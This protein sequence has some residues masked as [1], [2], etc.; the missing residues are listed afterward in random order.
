MSGGFRSLFGFFVF[1]CILRSGGFRLLSGY[2]PGGCRGRFKRLTTHEEYKECKF[3]LL[4]GYF[5]PLLRIQR[6]QGNTEY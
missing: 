2:L 5:G 6:M 1:Y 3:R 4:S